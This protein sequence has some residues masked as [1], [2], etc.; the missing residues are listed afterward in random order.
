M[1]EFDLLVKNGTI[2]TVDKGMSRKRWF[3]VKNGMIAAMGERDDFA[4]T[5]EN[6]IDL[7]GRTV[8]PRLT[9]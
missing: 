1:S 2:L 7:A 5:A 8:M 9:T 4:G 3:A 6:V